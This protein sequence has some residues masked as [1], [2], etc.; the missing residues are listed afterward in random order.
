MIIQLKL[1]Y[2]L[3]GKHPIFLFTGRSVMLAD[4][5]FLLHLRSIRSWVY[6]FSS[7]ILHITPPSL[8]CKSTL[9][10]D[11]LHMENFYIYW[12][13]FIFLFNTGFAQLSCLHFFIWSGSTVVSCTSFLIT[14]CLFSSAL[15]PLS[16]LSRP[17]LLH[18]A[19]ISLYCISMR[20]RECVTSTE[21][22]F[23]KTGGSQKDMR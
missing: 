23:L 18:H 3:P 10:P 7:N 14:P 20:S 4:V 1:F 15:H 9:H 16:P 8:V 6:T 11:L 22:V 19:L 2:A 17:L 13:L 5:F 21:A 12:I